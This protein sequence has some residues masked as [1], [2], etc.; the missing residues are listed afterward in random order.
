MNRLDTRKGYEALIQLGSGWRYQKPP[1]YSIHK[2]SGDM[3]RAREI[4]YPPRSMIFR[5]EAGELRPWDN[6]VTKRHVNLVGGQGSGKGHTA[7]WITRWCWLKYQEDQARVAAMEADDTPLSPDTGEWGPWVAQGLRCVDGA[8]F[9]MTDDPWFHAVNDPERINDLL[10][11][12]LDPEATIQVAFAEDLTS[13]LDKLGRSEAKEAASSWFKIR[14]KLRDASS[15]QEGLIMG[16]LG[17]HRF[18]GVP[19]PFTTDI[20]LMVFKSSS[21]NPYDNNIIRKYVGGDGMEFLEMLEKE[22][23]NDPV[24]KGYGI[25]CHKGEVGV[26]Y[27]PVYPGS[28]PFKQLPE[29]TEVTGDTGLSPIGPAAAKP[30]AVSVGDYTAEPLGGTDDPGFREEVIQALNLSWTDPALAERDRQ[31][32]RLTLQGETQITIGAQAGVSAS[33]VSQIQSRI[34]AE[35]LGYAGEQAYHLRHPELEYV[36]GNKP[37][38]DFIDHDARR[39][40]SFKCYHEPTLTET[41]LWVCK[42]VGREE[43]RY[44][45]SH[46]YGLE[47]LIYEMGRGRFYR[48]RYTLKDP[49]TE[50]L[51]LTAV[52]KA[53]ELITVALS[54]AEEAANDVDLPPEEIRA[55]ALEDLQEK[56]GRIRESGEGD[57]A[58]A[59]VD[60]VTT[61]IKR[62]AEAQP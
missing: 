31:V 40:I 45:R 54:A 20:D 26:W 39:V 57:I 44:S 24:F 46:G 58:P 41:A 49:G 60:D 19:P 50:D 3:K 2:A 5:H 38:P 9:D 1:R 21:T 42:R 10:I 11:H 52:A 48:Y 22:R 32:F 13:A 43:M 7:R 8:V 56:L 15:H 25:W 29:P 55:L 37:E 34:K 27:N 16:V 33:R 30:Q 47:M 28:D 51:D 36:G 35:A 59:L 17:L 14:H 23:L 12:G 4:L 62:Y 53:R 18:H 6:N 61:Y